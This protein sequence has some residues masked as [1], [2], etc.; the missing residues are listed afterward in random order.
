MFFGVLMIGSLAVS[1]VLAEMIRTLNAPFRGFA[2]SPAVEIL[3][4]VF[5]APASTRAVPDPIRRRSA[6]SIVAYVLW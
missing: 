3:R 5:L 6:A 1:A 4:Y 2:P